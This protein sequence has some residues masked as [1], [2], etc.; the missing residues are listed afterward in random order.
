MADR[1]A[2]YGTGFEYPVQLDPATGGVA[3][4]VAVDSVRASLR[5]LFDT[6]PGEDRFNPAYGCGLRALL[7]ETDTVT[8]RAL[9]DAVV[10]DA[11][12]K[13]EPRIAAIVSLDVL[14]DATAPNTIHIS[15]SFR[16]IRSAVVNNLVFPFVTQPG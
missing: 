9:L 5:R 16:L 10:R 6:T 4:A 13:W 14:S 8:L 2:L 3:A 7:F 1:N 12:R 11:I 15:V